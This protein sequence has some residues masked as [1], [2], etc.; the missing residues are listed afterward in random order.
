MEFK[1]EKNI[2]LP[3]IKGNG[4]RF[5]FDKMEVGDSFLMRPEDVRSCSGSA[6]RYANLHYPYKFTLRQNR[7]WRIR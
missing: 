1:I 3:T 6:N 2:P 4:L 5:P 7:C